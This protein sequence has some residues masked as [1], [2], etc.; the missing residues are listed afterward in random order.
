MGAILRDGSRVLRCASQP[1]R[2]ATRLS[3]T[4][5]SD[6]HLLVAVA[7]GRFGYELCAILCFLQTIYGMYQIYEFD[8]CNSCVKA[9]RHVVRSTQE[10]YYK[11][12]TQVYPSKTKRLHYWLLLPLDSNGRS[13]LRIT[14]SPNK[15]AQINR[16][17]VVSTFA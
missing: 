16:G 7:S 12:Q 17:A 9:S 6:Q 10:H 11:I 8:L 15:A 1:L 13:K 4:T 3:S 5:R 2:T 14:S